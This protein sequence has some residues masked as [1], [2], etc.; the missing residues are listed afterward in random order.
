MNLIILGL[1]PQ[2]RAQFFRYNQ[3][4]FGYLNLIILGLFPQTRAQFFSYNQIN[5]FLIRVLQSRLREIR[6]MEIMIQPW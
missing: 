1:F 5:V 6:I 4:N 3:I 2:T